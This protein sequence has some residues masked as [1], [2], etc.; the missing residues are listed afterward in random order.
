MSSS[1]VNFLSFSLLNSSGCSTGTCLCRGI[2]NMKPSFSLTVNPL[3][4]LVSPV[5]AGMGWGSRWESAARQNEC[6]PAGRVLS[7]SSPLTLTLPSGKTDDTNEGRLLVSWH[8]HTHTA[9]IVLHCPC[10]PP[11]ESQTPLITQTYTERWTKT[12]TKRRDSLSH[13]LLML[14]GIKQEVFGCCYWSFKVASLLETLF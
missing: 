3:K 12:G 14:L 10:C 11:R 2:E 8:Q 13:K 1:W 7:S 5:R 6:H 4:A 9:P